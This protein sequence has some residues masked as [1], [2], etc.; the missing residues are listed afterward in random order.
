M[1]EG[2]RS[3][4]LRSS[5]VAALIA[6]GTFVLLTIALRARG[7]DLTGGEPAAFGMLAALLVLG[8]L[9]PLRLIDR[10]IGGDITVTWSFAFAL[11]L[12]APLGAALGVLV[13]ASAIGDVVGHKPLE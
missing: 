1:A 8:E 2:S 9:R 5:Y 11:V 12:L 10:R 7:H 4:G 3:R 13:I 6:G